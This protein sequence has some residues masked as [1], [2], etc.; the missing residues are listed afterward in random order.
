MHFVSFILIGSILFTPHITLSQVFNEFYTLLPYDL[1]ILVDEEVVKKEERVVA[2]DVAVVEVPVV[3]T[4]AKKETNYTIV[5]ARV[6]A[7]APYDNKS[8]I[9]NDGDTL[10]SRGKPAGR[11][12][13]AVD[14]NLIPYNSTIEIE[15]FDGE[16]FIAGDTGGVMRN[17]GRQ[18]IY[19]VDVFFDTYQEA[20]AFGIQWREIKIYKEE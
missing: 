10:T 17:K 15:G 19:A 13:V 8:G 11:Q 18:G 12:Y 7:Y 20:M 2:E 5:D 1:T 16:V 14:P 9:C 6:S 4:V 3:K